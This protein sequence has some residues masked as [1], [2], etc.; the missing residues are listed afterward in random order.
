[1]SLW[2]PGTGATGLFLSYWSHPCKLCALFFGSYVKKGPDCAFIQDIGGTV[3]FRGGAQVLGTVSGAQVLVSNRY[4]D[5]ITSA[6]HPFLLVGCLCNHDNS[7]Q[8]FFSEPFFSS[9]F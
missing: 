8:I 2:A 9:W 3:G 7:I 5:Q 6:V 1:M 4:V